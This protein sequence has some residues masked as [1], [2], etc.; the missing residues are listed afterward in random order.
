MDET[1]TQTQG[2]EPE[3]T[4]AYFKAEMELHA[5]GPLRHCEAKQPK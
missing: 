4:P 3:A 2:K 5:D 1:Q